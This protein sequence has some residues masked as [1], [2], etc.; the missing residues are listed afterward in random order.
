LVNVS[1]FHVYQGQQIKEGFK[2]LAFSLRFQAIDRTLTDE[3]VNGL[4]EKIQQAL[5]ENFQA[6]LR[7]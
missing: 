7:A 1:L 2:S 3:E 6:E 5:Q 4:F